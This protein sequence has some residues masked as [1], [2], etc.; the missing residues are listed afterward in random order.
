MARAETRT[1][2]SLDRWAALIG[3]SPL[4][5]NGVYVRAPT[6]CEQPWLQFPYQSADRVGR[7][8][9]A[10]AIAQ[11][12][13]DIEKH[14]HYRLLPSWEVDEWQPTVRPTRPELLN[15][16]VTDLRGF[17]QLV[18]A[19]WG[20]LVSGGIRASTLE[21][22][23]EAVAYSNED[24]DDYDEVATVTVTVDAA[25]DP[26]ELHVYV[27]VSNPMVQTGGEEQ[28]EIRPISVSITS[29]TA[30]IRFRR[31][32][33]VLPQLQLDLVPPTDDSHLRGVDGSVDANFLTTVDVYRVYNDPQRQVQ[34]LWEPFGCT[35][36]GGTGCESCA[37]STQEGCLIARGALRQSM[38]VYRPATWNSTTLEFD[39][40]GWATGRQP[41][42]LR[43]WY[44]A[45]Q[46]NKSFGCPTQ[47]MSG[48][49]ERIVA[50]YAASLLDRAVCECNNV[51]AWV[52]H[53]RRDL[54][55][56]GEE[57]LQISQADLENPFGTRRGA[58]QAW[59]R[60]VG[61]GGAMGQGILP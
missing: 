57:G 36:C 2:L 48:D 38:L 16:S 7:E 13:S 30:T 46:R 61:E 43:L 33:A 29:T 31:E 44:Y 19:D 14:L 52:D 51:H 56:P 32:Q 24:G 35:T 6:V 11:A 25:R 39:A 59:H 23:G 3:I 50:Y 12:E 1:K 21:S 42:A 17:G 15:L 34:F 45:G 49:W 9:V 5:F 40:A 27:P 41:D 22:V 47:V 60:V 58:V 37:Y 4:H 10:Q 55:I 18:K 28:W 26:C 20:H 53:W 8:D 54:R